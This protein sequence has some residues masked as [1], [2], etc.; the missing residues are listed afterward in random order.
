VK[1]TELSKNTANTTGHF[2]LEGWISTLNN[3]K[4]E[5]LYPKHKLTSMKMNPLG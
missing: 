5:N 3:T 2:M 4:T 1:A